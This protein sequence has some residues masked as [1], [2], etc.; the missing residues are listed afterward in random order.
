ME[1]KP[2]YLQQPVCV[3]EIDA[4]VRLGHRLKQHKIRSIPELYSATVSELAWMS[5]GNIFWTILAVGIVLYAIYETQDIYT[6]SY[7]YMH[8]SFARNYC[9]TLC[10]KEKY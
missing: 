9:L 1:K 8:P 10:L 7:T 2:R 6:L 5:G 4:T 3:E